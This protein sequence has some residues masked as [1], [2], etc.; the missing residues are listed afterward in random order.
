LQFKVPLV[1]TASAP[2]SSRRLTSH[3]RRVDA[4]DGSSRLGLGQILRRE[5]QRFSGSDF[6]Q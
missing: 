4:A 2:L 1:F 6:R 3:L 5:T